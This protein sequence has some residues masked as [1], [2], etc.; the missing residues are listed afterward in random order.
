MIV[1]E[2]PIANVDCDIEL[3]PCSVN[4]KNETVINPHSWNEVSNMLFISQPLGTG[5]DNN[6]SHTQKIYSNTLQAS[7]MLRK[8]LA[9]STPSLA[10]LRMLPLRVFR[11]ATLSSM[12]L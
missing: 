6:R 9:L 8:K 7:P 11:A 4:E 10:C 2:I 12:P 3:G 5:M 1:F